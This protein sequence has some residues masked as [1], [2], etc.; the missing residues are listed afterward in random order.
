LYLPI[1]V[2]SGKKF[3]PINRIRFLT[4]EVLLLRF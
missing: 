1:P 2:L 4:I 3:P